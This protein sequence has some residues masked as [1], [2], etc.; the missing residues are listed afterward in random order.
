MKKDMKRGADAAAV[1]GQ[2]PRGKYSSTMAQQEAL[3]EPVPVDWSEIMGIPYD[4]T[5]YLV[6]EK[7]GIPWIS[8]YGICKQLEL[9]FA[10][11]VVKIT[12]DPEFVIR[13]FAT[14]D[15]L[16]GN[17]LF[18]QMLAV[19]QL[20]PWLVEIDATRMETGMRDKLFDYQLNLPPLIEESCGLGTDP[21]QDPDEFQ[22]M[23]VDAVFGRL[24][25]EIPEMLDLLL[26]MGDAAAKV[27]IL[28][29][30]IMASEKFL[31]NMQSS[32]MIMPVTD[33]AAGSPEDPQVG[34]E[35]GV[36]NG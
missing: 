16:G 5:C 13:N 12:A 26:Q 32:G 25:V 3:R 28:Y 21:Q 31:R 4:G 24:R 1:G 7:F 22:G 35:K 18:F 27:K 34:K 23:R 20:G 36:H 6:I 14:L 10:E 9:D 33:L 8:V 19:E 30:D 11:Q 15:P 29:A 2:H 17:C